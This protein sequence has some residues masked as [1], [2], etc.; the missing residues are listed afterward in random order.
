[1]NPFAAELA[2]NPD[3]VDRLL[4]VHVSDANGRCAACTKAGT[5]I[6]GQEWPCAIGFHAIAAR[7]IID[8]D[9]TPP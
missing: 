6:P 4:R 3:V 5:G 7:Q 2:R 9:A 1:M 8:G